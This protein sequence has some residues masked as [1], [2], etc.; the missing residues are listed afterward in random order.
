MVKHCYKAAEI[1]GEGQIKSKRED[2]AWGILLKAVLDM[3]TRF[4]SSEQFALTPAG[5]E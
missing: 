5:R 2:W 4:S 1:T 3:K